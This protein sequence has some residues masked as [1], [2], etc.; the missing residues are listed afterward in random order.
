MFNIQPT[1]RGQT[2]TWASSG[3]RSRAGPRTTPTKQTATLGGD[4]RNTGLLLL[5]EDWITEGTASVGGGIANDGGTL[6]L[7]RS[8]VSGNHAST[9]GGEGGG[10]QNYG[11]GT[12][13][14]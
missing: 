3:S 11:S 2:A 6:V 10:I 1:L 8:L 13:A 4:I 12:T 9:G 14:T 5:S 7:E